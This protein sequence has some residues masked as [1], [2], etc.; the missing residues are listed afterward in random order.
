MM[1][2]SRCNTNMVKNGTRDSKQ[3]YK[4]PKCNYEKQVKFNSSNILYIPDLHQPFTHKNAL[5]FVKEVRDEFEC[6]TIVFGGDVFDQ[7]S[8]SSY[9]KDPDHLTTRNE[10]DDARRNIKAWVK[11]FP[12]AKCIYGNHEKRLFKRLYDANIPFDL[13]NQTYNNIWGIPNTW[14]WAE[15]HVI[16]NIVFLHGMREGEYAHVNTAKDLRRSLV[17]CHTHASAGVH[18][19]AS[20]DNTIFA[21]N[22]GCLIDDSSYAFA[23]AK[24]FTRRPV[25]GCGVVVDGIPKFVPMR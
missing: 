15:R 23:Y 24:E 5:N 18:Y 14:E 3:R 25:L 22:A 11:A 6:E 8:L 9:S 2:C 7:Y 19:L 10:Y 17:M 21:M 20:F 1:Q 16:D 13:L 4:C 12:V